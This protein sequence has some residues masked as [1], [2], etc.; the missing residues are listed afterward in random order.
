MNLRARFLPN[1]KEKTKERKKMKGKPLFLDT[2]HYAFNLRIQE[3][4]AG[5]NYKYG[6]C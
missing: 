3:P 1:Y 6:I 4:E 5:E 2:A